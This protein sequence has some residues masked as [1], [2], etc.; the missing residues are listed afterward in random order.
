LA[1][2]CTLSRP[3]DVEPMNDQADL[4][5]DL[6]AT[7]AGDEAAFRRLWDRAGPT[8]FGL[9]LKMLRRRDAAE[10]ALQD[11]F[12]NIWRK[13]GLYDPRR[14]QPLAWILTVARH[15]A[16]DRLRRNRSADADVEMMAA[17]DIEAPVA[18]EAAAADLD[19]CLAQL[20]SMPRQAIMLAYFQGMSHTEIAH[21][22]G[23]P[24]GT[25]KSWLRRGL[26]QLRDCLES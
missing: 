10:D 26:L 25:V 4:A 12:V 20:D 5:A 3:V 8:M 14:G 9:C 16:L 24:L 18:P 11:A 17:E 13:A 1:A 2:G 22:L 7:A 6:E 21:R 19:R 15:V 23:A